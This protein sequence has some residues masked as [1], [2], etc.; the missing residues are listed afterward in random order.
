M[1]WQKISTHLVVSE[2]TTSPTLEADEDGDPKEDGGD[3]NLDGLGVELENGILGAAY[4][5]QSPTVQN[6]HYLVPLLAF[7]G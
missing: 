4:L 2:V 6:R 1:G 3:D 7:L 5:L